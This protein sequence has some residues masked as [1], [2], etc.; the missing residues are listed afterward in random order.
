MS[1]LTFFFNKNIIYISSVS[2]FMA[3]AL[4][5]I[6][7]L[8]MCFLPC[9]NVSIFY[10]TSAALLSLLNIVLISLTNSS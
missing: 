1:V 7:K 10:L 5:S 6:I 8:A 2:A 3:N 9:L 4:N